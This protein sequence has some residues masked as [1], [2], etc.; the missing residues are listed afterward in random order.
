MIGGVPRRLALLNGTAA[1]AVV[2]GLHSLWCLPLF[3]IVHFVSVALAKRD[4]YFL[5][6][7]VRHLRHRS[8]YGV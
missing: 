8:H 4:P 2:L 1:G 6:V 3:L 7:I 5:E